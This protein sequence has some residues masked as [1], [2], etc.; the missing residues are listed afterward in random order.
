[1]N[2]TSDLQKHLHTH[3]HNTHTKQDTTEIKEETE[4]DE[5]EEEEI[6][7]SIQSQAGREW[8]GAEVENAPLWSSAESFPA[9][10]CHLPSK[11]GRRI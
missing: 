9:R 4:E 6:R 11:V 10:G 3:A 5:E 8:S 2:L 7:A 1:M